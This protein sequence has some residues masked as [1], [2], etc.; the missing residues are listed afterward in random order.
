LKAVLRGSNLALAWDITQLEIITDSATV[1]SWVTS[2]IDGDR[3]LRV[4]GWE[5]LWC[6]DASR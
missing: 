6:A 3:P 1:Q 5:R 2:L 4:K